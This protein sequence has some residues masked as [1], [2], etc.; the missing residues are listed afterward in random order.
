MKG[1]II[2]AR[3]VNLAGP[4]TLNPSDKGTTKKWK[5][6]NDTGERIYDF[7]F[8]T[9]PVSFLEIEWPWGETGNPPDMRKVTVR[10]D[11]FEDAS[12]E[13][14]DEIECKATLDPPIEKGK[15]FELEFEFDDPF[16]PKEYIEIIP[17]D[18]NGVTIE[19][20]SSTET[21]EPN[22]GTQE[23]I[24]GLGAIVKT[25]AQ[26]NI[27]ETKI[28]SAFR[29]N[30]KTQTYMLSIGPKQRKSKKAIAVK[31]FKRKHIKYKATYGLT[32]KRRS[33]KKV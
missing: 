26:L 15:E 16:E 6:K 22:T 28:Q 3:I 1:E 25:L 23:V 30:E 5:F 24:E 10:E 12:K 33:R 11:G 7:I 27:P 31:H 17:T 21:D 32:T 9:G 19:D 20:D 13:Y 4:E 29:L 2:M 8:A 18:K 14:D